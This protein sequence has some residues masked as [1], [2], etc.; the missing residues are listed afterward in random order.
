[1]VLG[2]HIHRIDVTVFHRRLWR[3]FLN[4]GVF[5]LVDTHVYVLFVAITPV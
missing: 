4:L 2:F 5:N 3:A 1:M